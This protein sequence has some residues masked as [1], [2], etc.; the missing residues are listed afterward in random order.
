M[1]RSIRKHQTINTK[2]TVVYLITKIAAIAEVR[3]I[4]STNARQSLVHPVP[5]KT[6]LQPRVGSEGVPVVGEI[7]ETVPHGVCVFAE[8]NRSCMLS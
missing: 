5:N 4:V 6:T 1:W 8:D 3:H 7:P 2:L